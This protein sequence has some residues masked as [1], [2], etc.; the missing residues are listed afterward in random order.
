MHRTL[1]NTLF[2]CGAALLG[3]LLGSGCPGPEPSGGQYAVLDGY[4]LFYVD[5]GTNQPLPGGGTTPTVL[6]VSGLGDNVT[7]WEKV[8]KQLAAHTRVIAYDRGGI[9]WSDMGPNPRT[10]GQIALELRNLL[11]VAE[12][13]GPYLVVGHS[14]GGLYARLFAN[15]YPDDVVGMVL[16]DAVHEDRE[17]RQALLLEP[18]SLRLVQ[19]VERFVTN[20]IT[21]GGSLGEYQNR[22]NTFQEIRA[23]RRLPNIPLI[24]LSRD[25]DEFSYLPRGS[26]PA[27]QL[28][29]ELDE[30]QTALVPR[31]ELRVI[32]GSNHVVQQDNPQAVV[33]AIIDVMQAATGE[34]TP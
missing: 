33:K 5:Q 12:I 24:F 22:V 15:A 19:T 28:E 30:G 25:K 20:A 2:I 10:G 29:N 6:L 34:T 26:A 32:T 27:Y 16:V 11:D 18:G 21:D 7:V 8:Q 23:K 13:P 1:S 14:F 3:A 17:N 9:G 4:N 31:G